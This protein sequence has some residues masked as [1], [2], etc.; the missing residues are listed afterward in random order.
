MHLG[1]STNDTDLV[2]CSFYKTA[3]L[4]EKQ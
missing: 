1:A 4:L 2:L 3:E